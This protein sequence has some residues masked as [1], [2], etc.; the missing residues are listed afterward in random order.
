MNAKDARAI[1]NQNTRENPNI[2]YLLTSIYSII[3]IAAE[4]GER[5]I[6][7]LFSNPG[8]NIQEKEI[9]AVITH[10]TSEG[11]NIFTQNQPTNNIKIL[12]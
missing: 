6:C 10:L 7:Y 2:E 8:F 12:W 11:Y 1:S 5:T 9:E 4:K 3:R